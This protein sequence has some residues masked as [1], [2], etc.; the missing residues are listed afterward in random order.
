M[1]RSGFTLKLDLRAAPPK[2]LD[3]RTLPFALL[4]SSRRREKVQ[5]QMWEMGSFPPAR[6]GRGEL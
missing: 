2:G 4:D 3:T 1:T 5:Q 6:S